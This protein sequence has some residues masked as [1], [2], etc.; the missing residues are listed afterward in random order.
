MYRCIEVLFYLE[1]LLWVNKMTKN[2]E[3]ITSQIHFIPSFFL[4]NLKHAKYNFI[5]VSNLIS[6]S[7]RYVTFYTT[8]YKGE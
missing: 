7:R 1:I 6:Q 4:K 5:A 2:Y 3:F 8:E